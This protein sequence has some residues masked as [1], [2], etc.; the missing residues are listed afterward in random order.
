VVSEKWNFQSLVNL[1]VTD[2][3]RCVRRNAK[4]LGLQQMQLPDVA[5]GSG[6]PDGACIVHHRADELLVEQHTVSDG[7][8]ASITD[9]AKHAQSLSCLSS[10]LVVL[11]RPGQ[12]CIKGHRKVL[13]CFDTL[14]WLFEN[15]EWSNHQIDKIFAIS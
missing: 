12:P 8:A 5:A 13:C 11:C 1:P 15:V 6:P 3:P 9:G 7:Q 10:N 2:V 4:T 14:Y